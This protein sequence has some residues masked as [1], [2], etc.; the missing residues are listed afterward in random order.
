M[1]PI[2]INAAAVEGTQKWQRLALNTSCVTLM[3]YYE[4]GSWE[5]PVQDKA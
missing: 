2:T 4:G 3:C 1:Q 5:P